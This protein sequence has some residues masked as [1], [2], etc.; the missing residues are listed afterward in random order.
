[1]DSLSAIAFRLLCIQ[2]TTDVLFQL[3]AHIVILN[4]SN[5]TAGAVQVK[6]NLQEHHSDYLQFNFNLENE[7]QGPE[8]Q[9]LQ[10]L[11]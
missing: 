9:H 6:A 2:R 11:Q 1:M 10:W 3:V 4:K 8:I 5:S 7:G